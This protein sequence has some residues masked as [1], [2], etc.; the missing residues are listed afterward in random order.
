MAFGGPPWGWRAPFPST[1][2]VFNPPQNQVVWRVWTPF[3]QQVVQA[4]S[5][6][7]LP[8]LNNIGMSSQSAD[9]N[10][11]DSKKTKKPLVDRFREKLNEQHLEKT[12]DKEEQVSQAMEALVC[13]LRPGVSFEDLE[14][15]WKSYKKAEGIKS[16]CEKSGSTW[17]LEMLERYIPLDQNI[18]VI[19]P[20]RRDLPEKEM[21]K[22]CERLDLSISAIYGCDGI[23]DGFLKDSSEYDIRMILDAILQPLCVYKKVRVGTEKT[24]KY[25][26]LPINRCDYILYYRHCPIG[27]VETKRPGNLSDNSLVQLLVQLLALSAREPNL[28]YFGVLFDG[29]QFSFAGVSK[30]KVLFFQ[31]SIVREFDFVKELVGT[32]SWLIDLAKRSSEEH[33]SIEDLVTPMVSLFGELNIQ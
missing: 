27:V 19:E 28:F 20:E 15:K 24:I 32:M 16:D 3:Y 21:Q 33:K 31:T 29:R 6:A 5:E 22:I 7:S 10:F 1:S 30:N 26:E 13:L 9:R 2:F 4:N 25:N 12:S 8:P 14:T 18:A 11:S 23:I 17:T